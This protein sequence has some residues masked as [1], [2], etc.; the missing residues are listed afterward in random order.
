MVIY[1][2]VM[3]LL[4]V[5][6]MKLNRFIGIAGGGLP[7]GYDE[8]YFLRGLPFK[9][10]L[11]YLPEKHDLRLGFTIISFWQGLVQDS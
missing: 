9:K 3:C 7:I 2:Q 4:T 10:A 5:K 1:L 6:A 11:S 8:A